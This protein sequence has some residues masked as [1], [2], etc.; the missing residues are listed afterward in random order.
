MQC[1][2]KQFWRQRWISDFICLNTFRTSKLSVCSYWISK[3]KE[4]SNGNNIS[5]NKR[6][7]DKRFV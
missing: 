7:Y 4:G 5:G 2:L 6:D 1:K 3:T